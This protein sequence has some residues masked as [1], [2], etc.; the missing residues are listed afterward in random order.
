MGRN[1]NL[2]AAG[3]TGAIRQTG[4][5]TASTG[6][7]VGAPTITSRADHEVTAMSYFE[8]EEQRLLRDTARNFARREVEPLAN[9]IDREEKTPHGLIQRCAETGFFGVCIPEAYGGS[10]GTLT[11][12]CIILEEIAKASP[13]LAGLLSV[14]M[15][16]CPR[17]VLV[18]GNEAQKQRLLRP[19]AS[20]ERLMAYSQ[21]EPAGAG[22][23]LHHQ[24]RLREDGNGY[25]LNGAKLFCTQGEAKTYLVMTRTSRNGQEGYGCV[26]VEREADGFEVAPYEDKLGWRGT[27]TG[28]ISFNEVRVTGD[29]VLGDL[30][31]GNA[32]H[33]VPCSQA[34]FMGHS[35]SSLGCGEGM[36]DKTVEYVKQRE[37]YDEPMH[38]LSPISYWLAEVY[39][40]I[41]A[42]RCL[43]YASTR[44]FDEGRWDRP[45]GSICKAYICDAMM[46]S[47]QRLLQ[48][49]GGSGMMNS[50]GINRYMRDARIKM[51]AEGSTEMHTSIIAR[52]LLGLQ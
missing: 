45:I 33:H 51:V 49:W 19:S 34:G 40:K 14:Q 23:I 38:R 15:I 32:D 1:R 22:N 18:L 21:T 37:L 20:G 28:P 6:S 9:Q 39:N 4:F 12:A 48:M 44:L 5:V 2:A 36:L 52:G 42:S 31:T 8:N 26:V 11:D 7:G 47:T 29:N 43:L 13:S 25:R 41:E 35:A 10:G 3:G 27:N 24:T 30:L 50:T 17:T 16:L 46:D